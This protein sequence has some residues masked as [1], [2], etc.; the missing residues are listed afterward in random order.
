MNDFDEYVKEINFYAANKTNHLF[1]NMSVKGFYVIL[2]RLLSLVANDLVIC[3]KNK[4]SIFSSLIPLKIVCEKFER[5][6]GHI[7]I[8]TFNGEMDEELSDLSEKFKCLEYIPA[9][10]E[11]GSKFNNFIVCDARGYWLEDSDSAISR[12]SLNEDNY[13]KACGN[14]NDLMKSCELIQLIYKIKDKLE[15]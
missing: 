6:N 8:L 11:N 4:E 10:I 3:M 13:F 14:F 2:E 1:G 7:L 12:D 9:S 15:S 5:T